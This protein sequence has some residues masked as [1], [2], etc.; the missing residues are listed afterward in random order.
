VT[1]ASL[2]G[3]V[4]TR[5]GYTGGTT[6]NPTYQTVCAG[7]GHTE[8]LQVCYNPEIVTFEDVL[9]I[10]FK[11]HNPCIQ[12]KAQYKSAI[13]YANDEQKAI[14]ERMMA[15]INGCA[16]DLEPLGDWYN[17]EEYHQQFLLKNRGY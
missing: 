17:A 12:A 3:V 15:Q 13:Y 5:V 2:R 9:R 11:E 8:A 16:T 4:W 14:A 10:F 1:Y 7:D 6:K